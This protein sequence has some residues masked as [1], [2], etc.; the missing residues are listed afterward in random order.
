[1]LRHVNTPS[2]A[3]VTCTCR[4]SPAARSS[5]SG[6]SRRAMYH[7]VSLSLEKRRRNTG[8][9]SPF[10]PIRIA[11]AAAAPANSAAEGKNV[12]W[13]S[14]RISATIR[15]TAISVAKAVRLSVRIAASAT[16]RKATPASSARAVLP[17]RHHTQPSTTSSG[18]VASKNIAVWLA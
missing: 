6:T 13:R 3:T 11:I 7:A 5:S 10:T 17:R 15:F 16:S 2:L 12:R 9:N 18:R 1:M 4:A 14:Q 8:L